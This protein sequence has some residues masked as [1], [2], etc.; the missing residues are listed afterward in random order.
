MLLAL[1][2][3]SGVLAGPITSFKTD[4]TQGTQVC[5]F[6]VYNQWNFMTFSAITAPGT[7]IDWPFGPQSGPIQPGG[8][9]WTSECPVSINGQQQASLLR[10]VWQRIRGTVKKVI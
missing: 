1:V 6:L 10:T 3:I 2:V 8:I 4:N 9:R 7:V 5:H